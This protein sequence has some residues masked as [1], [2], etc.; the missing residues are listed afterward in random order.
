MDIRFLVPIMVFFAGSYFAV[1]LFAVFIKTKR[2]TG[3]VGG[4]SFEKLGTL[5][6]ALAGTL[7][8]GNIFGV[9]TA[10]IIG[11]AGSVFWLLVSSLFSAVIKYAEVSLSLSF[12]EGGGISAVLKKS[13]GGI[14]G[15]LSKLYLIFALML[16]AVMGFA[17]QG[18]SC[19]ECLYVSFGT[20]PLFSALVMIIVLL[21]MVS[22][23]GEKIKKITAII[24]PLTTIIYIIMTFRIII[25][26]FSRFPT[27][28]NMILSD[29]FSLDSGVGGVLG[30]ITSSRI[31]EG[32]CG[33]ILSNEAGAGT[34]SFAHTS[35]DDI[36]GFGGVLEVIFDTVILC[37]LTAFAVLVS[38]PE[39]G[40]YTSGAAL[41]LHSVYSAF[42]GG[43][44]GALS[45]IVSSFALCTAACWY[46]YSTECTRLLFGRSC[47][48]IVAA[49]M[50]L[51]ILIGS[52]TDGEYLVIASHYLLLI[53]SLLSLSALIKNS[54]RVIKLTLSGRN[55]VLVGVRKNRRF[56]MA[57]RLVP[58]FGKRRKTNIT[59]DEFSSSKPHRGRKEKKSAKR[60]FARS[61]SRL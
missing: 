8:V 55:T 47:G 15:V 41:I 11:G 43:G 17:L 57:S 23:R 39:V 22:G 56:G 1:R 3:E 48:G 25:L 27:V 14:G 51:F 21:Y 16:G 54:D 19:A 7:G 2:R 12:G 28:V 59:K 34:S 4:F 29:A 9:A 10:I 44:I 42:G 26:N 6:L 45:F 36:G 5:T 46:Y 53:L 24:I 37:M 30:F 52:Y 49:V 40:A 31:R 60:P 20:P 13:F 33:G 18:G 50:A 35:G 32:Y 58:L 61:F 38:V